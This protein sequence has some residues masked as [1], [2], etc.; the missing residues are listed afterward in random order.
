MQTIAG[1]VDNPFCTERAH[2]ALPDVGMG[3]AS[4]DK[5]KRRYHVVLAIAVRVA[6]LQGIVRDYICHSVRGESL[7]VFV[8]VFVFV[9]VFVIVSVFVF[10]KTLCGKA[11]ALLYIGIKFC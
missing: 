4:L 3:I 7:F 2:T 6:Y 11:L 5:P 9:F 1:I 8:I 10:V